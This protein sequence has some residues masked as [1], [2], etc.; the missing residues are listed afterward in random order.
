MAV[1]P[2]PHA[3]SMN[4]ASPP[5]PAAV[6]AG[7][8]AFAL[9][10][11]PARSEL[12]AHAARSVH[13]AG[14]L[15]HAPGQLLH[16]LVLVESGAVD[17]HDPE[18]HWSVR[19]AAGEC[20]GA[21]ASPLHHQEACQATAAGPAV[22]L[23][24]PLPVLAA[25]CRDHPELALFFPSLP[26]A[27]SAR[28]DAHA[29]PAAGA[30]L[31]A[32]PVRALLQREPVAL[33]PSTSIRATA[34]TM[35]QQRVSSVLL[36]EG[37]QLFGVVTDRDLRNRVLA[38][39]LDPARPVAD[40]ATREPLT[41]QGASPA[42]EALLLMAR[43]NI[44]H[45]PV[46]EGGRIAGMLTATSLTQQHTTSPVYLAGDIQRQADVEGLARISTRVPTLL[47]HL[48]AADASAYSA[49]HIVTA[50]TDALTVRLI[51]LAEAELGP[52]PVDYAWVAAGSQ[53]RSEQTA[54]TDQDNC[55]VLD[56]AFDAGRHGAYFRA[57]SRLVCEGLAACGYVHCPG[58]MM[59]MTECWRQ[60]RHRW[61]QYFRQ[62]TGEPEPEALMLTS[63]FFD[64]R[65]VHGRA[66][67]LDELR[68]E[69]L[70][71][72]EAN[73][74]FLSH[75]AG[76]ALKHRPPLNLFGNIALPRGG[77]H[78]RRLDLKHGG[79]VP[80]V[81]LA[82]VYALGA[83]VAAVNT[84]DRL[85]QAG[86]TAEIS[87]EAARD[88]RD[89]LEFIARQRIAHQARQIAR[90]EAPDNF[91]ALAEFSGFER[92]HLRDA[93]RVVQHLQSALAQRYG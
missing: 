77:E 83:G 44:H 48:A 90:G 8:R 13:D 1:S 2:Q 14:D 25:A 93:F 82:R 64:Q 28:P 55:L 51:Q 61:L 62:W 33:P 76:N 56:D 26:P 80:I 37:E 20:F 23:T 21:G 7:H 91:L 35:R 53:A 3:G 18:A 70:R 47:R 46:L 92:G 54:H 87:L 57:F 75:L 19:L 78:P 60:P 52:A 74:L 24:L 58:G 32:T 22:L 88:L 6:L 4:A 5:D 59:A 9:L 68:A 49:G 17:L 66:A 65:A 40:V 38:Q 41:V 36:V 12:A 43:H 34:E 45:L 30:N 39:E 63:V 11:A 85:E 84:H 16:V 73:T 50:I 86:G 15:T 27:R 31:L 69:V 42:F 67:L 79:I 71:R 29:D 89:A 10:P 72:T 81:D